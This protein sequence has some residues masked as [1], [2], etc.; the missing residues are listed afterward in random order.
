MNRTAQVTLLTSMALSL[1]VAVAGCG[2]SSASGGS[3]T[4][5]K[6]VYLVSSVGTGWQGGYNTAFI[7]TLQDQGVTVTFL[8]DP[9]DVSKN[10]ANLDQAIAA[11]PTAVAF[12]TLSNTA[13]LPA[14]ERA[15]KAGV[16]VINLDGRPDDR[17]V[18]LLTSSLE[19]DNLNQGKFAAQNIVEGLKAQGL[20]SANIIALTGTAA[21]NT[22]QDRMTGFNEVLAQHPQYK[23]VA[24]EDANWDQTKTAQLAQQLFAKYKSEGGIQAAYGMADN[25]AAGIIQ[26]AKQA[27]LALGGA[28]GLIVT[29]SN[30]YKVGIDA[31][32]DGTQYGTAT[33]APGVEGKWAADY[34]AKFVDGQTIPKRVLNEEFR[35]TKAN[36]EKYA[37][38]CSGA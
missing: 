12:M 28:K 16:P 17:G 4:S 26:A 20:T 7:K 19:S 2:S 29:G 23:L 27:D 21:T 24:T 38:E 35:V 25:Q 18:P 6:S 32:K 3:S 10:V 37:P 11:K 15:K 5:K 30:C 13:V 9:F 1:G 31:I 33:Q 14:L 22:V 36:V 34:V 8:Q